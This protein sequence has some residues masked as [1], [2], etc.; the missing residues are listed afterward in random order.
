MIVIVIVGAVIAVADG[1][2]R[3][4]V[5]ERF[6]AWNG[7]YDPYPGALLFAGITLPLMIIYSRKVMV[8]LTEGLF[9]WF[10]FCTTAYTKDFSYIR[11]PGTPLFVTDVVLL[12]LLLSIYVLRRPR[13]STFPLPVSVLLLLFVGAGA[14]SAVRGFLGHRDAMVVLRDSA[15]VGYT[16]FLLVGYHLFRTWLSIKRVA[17]WFLLGAALS[18][19][20]GLVWFIAVPEERRFIFYGI[21]ILIALTGTMLAIASRLLRSPVGWIFAGVL[22]LG[23]MLANTRSLFVSSAVVLFAGLFGG[24]LIHGEI[25]RPNLQSIIATAAV[26]ISLVAFLFLRTETGRDFVERSAEEFAT[27]FLNSAEDPDWQ[28][29]LSAWKEAW[30]RFAEYPLAGEGFGVPFIFDRLFLENDPRPHNTFF[31]VLYKMGL[32]GFLPVV[33]LLIYFQWKGLYSFRRHGDSRRIAFLQIALLTQVAFCIYGMANLLLESPFLASLFWAF[34]GLGL[35][36]IRMLY[37]DRSLRRTF[38][39]GS[40]EYRYE[41]NRDCS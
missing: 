36:I 15:L 28:F 1:L 26:M 6:A 7:E 39:A 10:V 19:I 30:R 37:L 22:C 14:L 8:S 21:Y 38:L 27:G 11:S 4:P 40:D 32:A 13:F 9:L 24:R 33:A 3:I 29:R 25:R 17:V 20:N 12:V 31:T 16:L 41:I 18:S 2:T 23:L 5:L 34:M 35:R